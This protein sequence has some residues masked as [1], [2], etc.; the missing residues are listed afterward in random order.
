[1][2]VKVENGLNGMIMERRRKKKLGRMGQKFLKSVE[3]NM[4]MKKTVINPHPKG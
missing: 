3:M 2:G 1:M 4:G